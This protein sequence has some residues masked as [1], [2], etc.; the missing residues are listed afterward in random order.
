MQL[1]IPDSNKI[2]PQIL[3]QIEIKFLYQHGKI[4]N[5]D[6]DKFL[7]KLVQFKNSIATEKIITD[8][9]GCIRELKSTTHAL[10]P[11]TLLKDIPGL[12]FRLRLGAGRLSTPELLSRR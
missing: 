9:H 4:V 12:R 10:A 5:E 11:A 1:G 7:R 3:K 6:F 2:N 8:H